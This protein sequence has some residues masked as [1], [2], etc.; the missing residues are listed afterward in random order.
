MNRQINYLPAASKYSFWATFDPVCIRS[1][2]Q[3][4]S[5][6]RLRLTAPPKCVN[7]ILM[8]MTV[9]K[10]ERLTAG[11]RGRFLARCRVRGGRHVS[12]RLARHLKV[13]RKQT[14]TSIPCVEREWGRALLRGERG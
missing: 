12:G 13:V 1:D 5:H 11:E 9:P 6:R 10:L 14:V 7:L 8:Y 2:R 4:K 3:S